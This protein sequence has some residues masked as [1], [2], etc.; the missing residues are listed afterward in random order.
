MDPKRV[1]RRAEQ[2]NTTRWVDERY[3][4]QLAH[5][6][7]RDLS[8]KKYDRRDWILTLQAARAAPHYLAEKEV[9]VGYGVR[10][11]RTRIWHVDTMTSSSGLG[12]FHADYK[13]D[14]SV[15][16]KSLTYP[17][18]ILITRHALE[19]LY[20]R[21]RTN[22]FDEVARKALAPLARIEPSPYYLIEATFE[23][24]GVGT[25]HAMSERTRTSLG[26]Y[27]DTWIVKTFI[28]EKRG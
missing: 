21:L 13:P 18:V 27:G 9:K 7:V 12:I 5:Q 20:Q 25:M 1:S 11:K 6:T 26:I 14:G 15:D 22:S 2:P 3:G 4:K 24:P 28:E 23:L 19:R 16:P 10:K 8:P 17:P